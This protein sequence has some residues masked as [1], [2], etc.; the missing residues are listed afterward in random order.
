MLRFLTFIFISLS[1]LAVSAEQLVQV[2][3]AEALVASQSAAERNTAMRASLGE[4]VVRVSGET[5]A[6]N[7]PNVRRAIAQA[8]TYVLEFSYASTDEQIEVDGRAVRASRLLLSFSPQAVDRL[9]RESGLSIWPA[10]RPK[11]LVW[12]VMRDDTGVMHRVPDDDARA[13]L[14]RQ[15]ALRGVPLLLPTY[16]LEDNLALSTEDLW[17]LD[18][19]AVT[20]ASSRYHPDAILV[21]RYSEGDGGW[22]ASWQLLHTSGNQ[23]FDTRGSGAAEVIAQAINASADYFAR[24]YSITAGDQ[25]AGAIVMRVSDVRDFASYKNLERYLQGLAM[26]SRM[27]LLR[28]EHDHL[29]IRLHT[30][31][32]TTVLL[33]TLQLGKRLFPVVSESVPV[34]TV[35]AYDREVEAGGPTTTA[36]R[37]SLDDPLIYRWQR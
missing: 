4:V 33:S 6:A 21:G 16:D 29:L 36:A 5:A 14:Y 10:S 35:G 2:Y 25:G 1:S 15:A 26:V 27:E 37:G 20:A 34:L 12:L 8:Q 22:L 17:N 3:R 24:R 23:G 32:D 28:T 11:L 9:L 7:H 19:A 31:G 30:V 13:A 18:E